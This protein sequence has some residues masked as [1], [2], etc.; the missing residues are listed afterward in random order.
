MEIDGW[1]RT[2]GSTEV[3]TLFDNKVWTITTVPSGFTLGGAVVRF[4]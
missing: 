1:A 3:V 4:V 2:E